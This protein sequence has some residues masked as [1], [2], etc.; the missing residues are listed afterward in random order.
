LPDST[1]IIASSGTTKPSLPLSR[2]SVPRA[3]PVFYANQYVWDDQYAAFAQVDLHVTSQFTVTLGARQEIAQTHQRNFSGTGLFNS[4]VPIEAQSSERETPFLP[5]ATLSYQLTPS[6]MV[7]ASASKGL[8][9]GGGNN[10]LPTLCAVNDTATYNADYLWSYELGT[11]D[12]FFGGRMQV[13]PSVFHV[14]WSQIQSAV[15]LACGLSYTA[16]LGTADS[17]GFDLALQVMVTDQLRVDL[18]VGYADA[19]YVSNAYTP[20]GLPLS[21]KGDAIQ[22]LNVVN[23]SW[24]VSTSPNYTFNLASGDKVQVRAQYIDHSRNN[25]P[26]ITGGPLAPAYAPLD[27][28]DPP[29]HLANLRAEYM[30][31]AFDWGLYLNNAF[32]S[33]P[34]LG[35]LQDTPTSNLTTHSTFR[36][37]TLGVSA[38]YSF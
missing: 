34:L 33:H 36:P 1:L 9:V 28:P 2:S 10:G 35:A 11:K 21:I 38:N 20:N 19:R 7:Y 4:G 37:R 23:P 32:N 22:A 14:R 3:N 8:R 30:T 6:D 5:K 27:V 31:G 13:D 17:D 12:R 24:D 16:N 25:R 18:N 26:V 29:T 15:L